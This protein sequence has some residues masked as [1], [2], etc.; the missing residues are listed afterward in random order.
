MACKQKQ[1]QQQVYWWQDLYSY[2]ARRCAASH[3]PKSCSLMPSPV[4][5]T[6]GLHCFASAAPWGWLSHFSLSLSLSL[7]PSLSLCLSF[8]LIPLCYRRG[9]REWRREVHICILVSCASFNFS[10]RHPGTPPA[11][12]SFLSYT[13]TIPRKP[14]GAF[15]YP[16]TSR[17]TYDELVLRREAN[18]FLSLSLS[19]VM[20]CCLFFDDIHTRGFGWSYAVRG[21]R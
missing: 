10:T 1:H 20:L 21:G 17:T 2:R 6:R 16:C 19:L 12:P 5:G 14:R 4:G 18:L 7:S 8:S 9:E 15:A 3:T 11:L 13:H